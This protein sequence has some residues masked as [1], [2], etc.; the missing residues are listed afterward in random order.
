MNSGSS[1]LLGDS[2]VSDP[3]LS[4]GV[5][6]NHSFTL[7]NN[8]SNWLGVSSDL[9]SVWV[10]NDGLMDLLIDIFA[11]LGFVGREALVPLGE[12]CLVL[13]WV[14]LLNLVHVVSDVSSENSFLMDLSVIFGSLLIGI[15]GLSSLVG[16]DLDLSSGVTWESLG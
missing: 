6:Q 3:L 14:L 5:L 15:G 9:L 12:K 7:G 8:L 10:G 1:L 4:L 16:D 11:G 13:G 2:G